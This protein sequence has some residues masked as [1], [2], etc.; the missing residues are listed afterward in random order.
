M[1]VPINVKSPNNISKWQMG[2]NSA[3][4]GLIKH[5][6]TYL[7]LHVIKPCRWRR[8]IYQNLVDSF[9]LKYLRRLSISLLN[10]CLAIA[11]P[12]W[13]CDWCAVC[14]ALPPSVAR[15]AT[16]WSLLMSH[17]HCSYECNNISAAT[18]LYAVGQSTFLYI[19]QTKCF[20]TPS[21]DCIT[22]FSC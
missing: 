1:Q 2:F 10:W 22:H 12:R 15:F 18:M 7:L 4:K 17:Y 20:C 8:H 14:H 5:L 11:V 3:F 6:M 13:K 16:P 19:A 9:N 21:S